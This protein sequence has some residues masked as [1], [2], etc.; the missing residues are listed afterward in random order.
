[1]TY[2]I[3]KNYEVR[4][5]HIESVSKNEDYNCLIINMK[6]SVFN[7]GYPACRTPGGYEEQL[8][9]LKDVFEVENEQDLIGKKFVAICN[10][11]DVFCL[12]NPENNQFFSLQAKFFPEKYAEALEQITKEHNI[13]FFDKLDNFNKLML[14]VVK[15]QKDQNADILIFSQLM[16]KHN[17]K[18]KLED[19]LVPIANKVK[20]HK[21]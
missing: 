6:I 5:G 18:A 12:Y 8:N 3:Y 21:I 9:Y 14:G 2:Q 20:T 13:E 4:E 16:D 15:A 19:K 1:M 11:C 17:L 7:Q 10:S